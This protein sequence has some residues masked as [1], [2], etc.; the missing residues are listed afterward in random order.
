MKKM[1]VLGAILLTVMLA[2]CDGGPSE[3]ELK[4]SIKTRF[5][6]SAQYT[7]GLGES[8]LSLYSV[9]KTGGCKISKTETGKLRC[10]VT[11]VVEKKENSYAFPERRS[12]TEKIY[13]WQENGEWVVDPQIVSKIQ[14]HIITDGS[15]LGMIDLE[16][17]SPHAGSLK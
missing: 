2:G 17:W 3:N 13:T 11:V 7:K 16:D 8:S 15:G 9:E 4:N 10:P 14:L 1:Q 12:V 6:E 5:D